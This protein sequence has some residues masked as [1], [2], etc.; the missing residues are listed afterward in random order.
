M[1]S[2]Y[3]QSQLADGRTGLNTIQNYISAFFLQKDRYNKQSLSRFFHVIS[4]Y[5]TLESIPCQWYRSWLPR[6][7][8]PDH[9]IIPALFSKVTTD[10]ICLTARNA[11]QLL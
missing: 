9:C 5:R 6:V 11:I 4:G 2:R 3:E 1:S 10:R 8:T 7:D